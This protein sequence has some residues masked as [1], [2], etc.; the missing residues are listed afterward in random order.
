MA[1]NTSTSKVV[2]VS[3]K[4][5]AT[6]PKALR[7][8]AGIDAPGEVLVYREGDRIIVEPIPSLEELQGIHAGEHEPGE[9]LDRVREVEEEER[10]REEAVADELVDRHGE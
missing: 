9:V 6:I 3:Q 10:Q 8:A 5:Q 7:E 2:R 1:S 4:G